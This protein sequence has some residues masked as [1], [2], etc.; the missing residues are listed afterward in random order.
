MLTMFNVIAIAIIMV[1]Y[2]NNKLFDSGLIDLHK[3]ELLLSLL[4]DSIVVT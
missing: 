1:S 4:K 2:Q 3:K